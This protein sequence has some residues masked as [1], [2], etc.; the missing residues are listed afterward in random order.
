MSNT[1]V[2]QYLAAKV[3]GNKVISLTA[4]YTGVHV[5]FFGSTMPASISPTNDY[6]TTNQ[7]TLYPEH[8]K[9][10]IVAIVVVISERDSKGRTN[11]DFISAFLK[12]SWKEKE[13]Q[14]YPFIDLDDPWV[15]ADRIG[16]VTNDGVEV[17]LKNDKRFCTYD[18]FRWDHN[19]GKNLPGYVQ[20]GNLLC[21]YLWGT[22]HAA[23]VLHAAVQKKLEPLATERVEQ[24]TNKNRRLQNENR[25]LMDQAANLYDQCR[26]ALKVNERLWGTFVEAMDGIMKDKPAAV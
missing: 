16:Q 2:S 10:G 4:L 24:V 25:R 21:R 1:K 19:K 20:D 18:H 8:G 17:M 13:G 15:S 23:D 5:R 6:G 12:V 22:A 7:M 26:D 9:D 11:S 14:K 3:V